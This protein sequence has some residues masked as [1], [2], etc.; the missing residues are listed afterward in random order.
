[1]VKPAILGIVNATPDSFSDGGRFLDPERAAKHAREL[2]ASGADA[3]DLG[4]ASSHP[5]A[6]P[7]PP[8]EEIARLA[9][10]LD[11]LVA[12]GVDVS[13]D[14][15]SPEVQLF[16]LA[17]GA[18]YL[19]DIRGFPEPALYP[20]LARTSAQLVVMHS[21]QRGPATRAGSDP[22]TLLADIDAFFAARIAALEAAGVARERLILD[23]GMGFFV[24][25]GAEPSL[26]VLRAVPALRA[27]FGLPVLVSVSRKSFLGALTGAE[28][29]A[30]GAAT[31]AAELF[32]A[33]RGADYIRTH[34]VRALCD[35]L[36][37]LRALEDSGGDPA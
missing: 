26:R 31:L 24:G 17:R 4:A 32:A 6:R 18:R 13:V 20:A 3:I 27:R 12:E 37:V 36:A 15:F 29:H 21:I 8:D 33:Q 25:R 30:R 23:P 34:D 5:D 9:P 14:S 22:A 1:M 7:V 11:A 16:A 19:N 2:V 28:V 10:V 35:G